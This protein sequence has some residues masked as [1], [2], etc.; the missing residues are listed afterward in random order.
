[1]ATPSPAIIQFKRGACASIPVLRDGEPGWCLDTHTLWVGSNNVNY[2]IGASPLTTKGD[3]LGFS[4]ADARIPVG[5]NGYVL[6]ADSTQTLGVKW[7]APSGGVTTSPLTTKGDVWVYSTTDARLPVGANGYVLTADS[8]QTAGVKWAALPTGLSSPLTTKG[9]LWTYSTTDNRLG[10]GAD[11]YVLTADSTATN[12]IKW[13]AAATTYT[14]E[15]AQDAVGGILTDTATIDFTYDD[16]G[17]QI[18]AVVIDNSITDAKFRQ[19]AALSVV[20]NATNATANTADITAASDYQ[21]LRRSGTGI[22]FGAVNLAQSA[23]VTGALAAANGGTGQS[24]YTAG[25]LL[26]ASGASTLSKLGIGTSGYV[27]SSTGSAP[28]WVATSALSF[29]PR[30]AQARLTTV[31]GTTVPTT[32]QS[33]PATIYYTPHHG[34]NVSIYNGSAWQT[35]AIPEIGMALS[36]LSAGFNYDIYMFYATATTTAIDTTND[37]VTFASDPGWATGAL[38]VPSTTSNGLTAGTS[39]FYR[40]NGVTG[41]IHTTLAGAIANTGKVDLTGSFAAITFAAVSLEKLVWTNDTTRATGLTTQ[42]GTYVKS[43]DTTRLFIGTCR[44]VATT[45]FRDSFQNRFIWNNYNRVLRPLM[46]QPATSSWTQSTSVWRPA[47]NDTGSSFSYVAGLEEQPLFVQVVGYINCAGSGNAG[48]ASGIGI[49]SS[50]T[51]HANCINGISYSG[52]GN[53]SAVNQCTKASLVAYPGI[54][55]HIAYML[56]YRNSG[57]PTWLGSGTAYQ[58]GMHG[59]VWM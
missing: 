9:D 49:D 23:A 8:T 22:G 13:A 7:A 42:N 27:L 1:M 17:N 54:G 12:G 28:A 15:M 35:Y 30:Y 48:G 34:E 18:T 47:N 24:S 37:T 16:A 10:V 32:D 51:L 56:E 26:Y 50:S 6:T 52:T 44:S 39:Y 25:D 33:T 5:A 4:S 59:F 31:S 43:G 29:S 21:V 3:L 19:S 41:T 46:F 2:K 40:A 36:G 57:T 45:Q 20:G 11:G 14:D 38:V 53:T 58:S 55:Y